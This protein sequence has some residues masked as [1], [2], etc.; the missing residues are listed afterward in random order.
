MSREQL[1][2]KAVATALEVAGNVKP[3]QMDAPTPCAE[4]D[5]RKLVNH[6]LFWGPSLNGAARKEPVPTPAASESDVDLTEGDWA[7]D[8]AAV[9]RDRADAWREPAAW[10]G[11][12]TLGGPQEMPAPMIG[13][14]VLGE[15]VVHTWDLARVTG[16]APSW[17]A[18]LL[19]FLHADLLQTSQ[20][21][22]DMGIYGPEV[23][24]AADAPLIER[25]VGLT[26]RTP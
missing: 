16:Q 26:G 24:V 3:D 4:F 10:E 21:G 23:P 22:R 17:D 15:T 8:L 9:L 18:D 12:T 5:V 11:T 7:A 25:I 19:E 14:M 2:D 20:M 6:L 1:I 13:A